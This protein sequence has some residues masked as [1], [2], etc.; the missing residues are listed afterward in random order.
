MTG[1]AYVSHMQFGKKD[2][3]LVIISNFEYSS[4]FQHTSLHDILQL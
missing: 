2:D 3:L 4:S 1:I